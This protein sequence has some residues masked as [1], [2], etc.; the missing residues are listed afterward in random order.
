[1]NNKS[2]RGKTGITEKIFKKTIDEYDC[3]IESL[4]KRDDYSPVFD[5]FLNT[6]KISLFPENGRKNRVNPLAG[7]LCVQAPPEILHA[8]GVDSIKLCSG[9]IYAQRLSSDMPVLMCPVLKSLAGALRFHNSAAVSPDCFIIPTSCDWVVKLPEMLNQ[10]LPEVHFLELPHIKENEKSQSRWLEEI[11]GL[12]DRLETLSGKKL[13][14]RNLRD[15][16]RKF[17]DA[18]AEFN[19]LIEYRRKGILPNIWFT[20]IANSFL[21]DDIEKWTEHIDIVL[22]KYK[23]DKNESTDS[24]VFLAGSPVFF[25]NL[26]IPLLIEE[27]GMH[28]IADDI[29]TCERIFPGAVCCDDMTIHG[30]LKALSE[31][32]HKACICPTFTDNERRV[33]NILNTAGTNEIKGVIFHV[34][35]GCHPY[36]IESITIEKKLK[37]RGFKFLRIETD[38]TKEDSRN[39]LTRLEAFKTTL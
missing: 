7:I 36:D 21:Q 10:E 24:R 38:Y 26:K 39:I 18:W 32:Y 23:Q 16:I 9:S 1:M 22:R 34:L 6:I 12:K 30:M 14:K 2:S 17:S 3:E 29:C 27:A 13:N 5:Y 20:V 15:S 11:Y 28:I 19:M 35:K 25:P 31:R 4:K 37:E 8:L 33:N